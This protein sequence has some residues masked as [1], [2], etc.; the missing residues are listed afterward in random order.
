MRC[1]VPTNSKPGQSAP[2]LHTHRDFPGVLDSIRTS[3][4]WTIETIEARGST[5]PPMLPLVVSELATNAVTHTRSS[6]PRSRYS[7]H[8]TVFDTHIRVAVRDA[9]PLPGRVPA[10][11]HAHPDSEHGRGLT[12]VET[13]ADRWGLL[14]SGSGVWAEVPR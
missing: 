11:L 13:F 12:L 8:L 14:S 9:G 3:R 2:A 4:A 1:T 7:L 6:A 10:R 5:V